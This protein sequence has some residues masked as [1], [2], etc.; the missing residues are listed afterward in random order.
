KVFEKGN[1]WTNSSVWVKGD[2]SFYPEWGTQGL[3]VLRNLTMPGVLSE[4]SFHDYIP[5]SWRLRNTS[6]LHHE[7]WAFARA[8]I[9]YKNVTPVSNG[10]IAGIVRDP[11]RSPPWYFKPGTKDVAVAL[12]GAKVTLQPGN[13]SYVVDNLNNGFFLF[14]SVPPGNYKLYFEGVENFMNDSLQVTVIANKSTLADISLQ[15]DTTLVPKLTGY[16]PSTT[17]SLVFNQE[18]TFTFDLS[19]NQDSV[20]KALI[21]TPSVQLIYTWGEKN[22]ILKVKPVLQYSPKTNYTVT[23]SNAACSK[24]NV[25]IAAP[26]QFNFVTK[27]RTKLKLEK[28]F[29]QAGQKGISLYPQVKLVFDA[30]LDPSGTSVNIQILNETGQQL[31]RVREDNSEKGGKGIYTFELSVPLEL[32]KSYR[33]VLISDLADITG[34]K[35]GENKEIIFTTR[36]GAYPTGSVIEPFD[37]I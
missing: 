33:V 15:Y 6:F 35:L 32:N 13:K 19:M 17:D 4:G 10:L 30:P 7:S 29:P 11:L 14:D 27:N 5:E 22:T 34:M 16:S 2:W 9:E 21:F 18:F 36:E 25:K 3:G 23:I 26:Y 12:N 20:Q 8:F 28:S 24:W 31:S 37:D 1:C